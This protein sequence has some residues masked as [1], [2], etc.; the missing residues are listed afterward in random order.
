[1]EQALRDRLR[2]QLL[3]RRGRLVTA[4]ADLG[5]AADLVELLR[6]VDAALQRIDDGSYG[7]CAVCHTPID[8]PDLVAIPTTEW[9]LC[10]LSEE[11]KT[12]LERDIALATRVQR[13]LLPR[14]DLEQAGFEAHYRYLPAGPVSG[15]YCDLIP[16]ETPPQGLLFL[17]GDVSGK[18]IAAALLMARLN[19]LFRTLLEV[20]L[21]VP[22]LLARASRLVLEGAT[23][24]QYATLVC[25]R[26]SAT[27]DVEI[28]NAGHCRPLLLRDGDVTSLDSTGF[29]LGLMSGEYGAHRVRLEPGD[30][31]FLY[32]DG[33][34]EARDPDGEEF[35]DARI[36]DV[37]SRNHKLA[38]AQLAAACLHEVARF[39]QGL[40]PTDDLTVL[41]VRR[42]L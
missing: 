5:D 37:L 21:D 23:G 24:I 36:A 14:P 18:G 29:P 7:E 26:A 16:R 40:R 32:T 42:A 11:Q 12:A 34:S 3:D 10:N 27:G 17:L 35:G 20:D 28:G 1:M 2:H 13:G 15:D 25:G 31:L 19:A 4:V 6:T 22:S 30:A 8:V 41:V 9:C 33:L 38:P 39:G